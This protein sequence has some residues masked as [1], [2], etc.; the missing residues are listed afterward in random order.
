MNISLGNTNTIKMT[1]KINKGNTSNRAKTPTKT[2][3][4][5]DKYQHKD[6]DK[7]RLIQRQKSKQGKD[8]DEDRGADKDKNRGKTKPNIYIKIST[9]I[10]KYNSKQG[11]D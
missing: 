2:K 9:N 4:I 6:I 3:I 5:T 10:D 11:R 8:K 7:H 1:I